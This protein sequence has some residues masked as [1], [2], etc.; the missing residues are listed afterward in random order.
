MVSK[1]LF[2]LNVTFVFIALFIV[3]ISSKQ[4]YIKEQKPKREH[5][6]IQYT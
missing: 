4:M 6:H 1:P 3:C 2:F 5:T